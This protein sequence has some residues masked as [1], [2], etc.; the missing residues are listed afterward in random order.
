VPPEIQ[1]V[2]NFNST[3]SGYLVDISSIPTRFIELLL[4]HKR[5]LAFLWWLGFSHLDDDDFKLGNS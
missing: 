3:T 2:W 4:P 5:R 1:L